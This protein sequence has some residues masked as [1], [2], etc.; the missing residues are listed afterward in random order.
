[1]PF[2]HDR[3]NADPLVERL[4]G[5]DPGPLD[6]DAALLRVHARIDG[7]T[8]TRRR[9]IYSGLVGLT[10]AAAVAALIVFTPL[11]G[12]ARQ[13]LTIFQAKDVAPIAVT[14]IDQEQMRL[15]P[16][17]NDFGSI[18]VYRK[19][20][21]VNVASVQQAQSMIG[22][23]PRM[24]THV[25]D[26]LQSQAH[27]RVIPLADSSFRFS[28]AKAAAFEKR[29][30]RHL[31]PM[32]AGLDGTTIHAIVG[33]GLVTVFGSLPQQ[34]KDEKDGPALKNALVFAQV[35]APKMT[36]NGASVADVEN[37]L[38]ALPNVPADLAVQIRA[39]SDPSQTLPIPVQ[40]NKETATKVQVD[41]VQGLAVGDQTGLGAGVIWQ[42][43]GMLYMLG[44]PMTESA[45]LALANDLK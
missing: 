24:I 10:C 1:M 32:P 43:N 21:A 29:F 5:G 4:L 11:G 17:A 8:A 14:S 28:A 25:P 37:Y 35:K 36:S 22:F 3:G 40:I 7:D 20:G 45:I 34:S 15:M 23:A 39:L 33:P 44:G 42:K 12:F 31:P 16:H 26:G 38:L 2:N 9:S 6:V 18:H 27:Y 41:G 19:R 13:L 30:H